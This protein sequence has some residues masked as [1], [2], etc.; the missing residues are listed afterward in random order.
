MKVS[1]GAAADPPVDADDPLG[2]HLLDVGEGRRIGIGDAL[3][4]AVVV[5][6]VDEE[7]TAMVAHAMHPAGQPD[8]LADIGFAKGAARV[9]PERM[10]LYFLT[11]KALEIAPERRIRSGGCQ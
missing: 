1:D 2:A 8:R 7:Q 4:D 9:R 11:L 3:R 6:Q 10:H 5:A